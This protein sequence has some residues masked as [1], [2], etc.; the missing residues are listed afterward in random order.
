MDRHYAS[1]EPGGLPASLRRR[2]KMSTNP[3]DFLDDGTPATPQGATQAFGRADFPDD[4]KTE[5]IRLW[6]NGEP[7]RFM[8]LTTNK[9]GLRLNTS[10][11]SLLSIPRIRSRYVVYVFSLQQSMCSRALDLSDG[12][13]LYC[14]QW[15]ESVWTIPYTIYGFTPP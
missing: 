5:D 6:K 8:I 3:S 9:C 12:T 2:H 1:L 4:N 7:Y 15:Q 11:Y 13:L 10:K 14:D